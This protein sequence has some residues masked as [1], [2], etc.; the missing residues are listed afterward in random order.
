MASPRLP[1]DLN[2]RGLLDLGE[3]CLDSDLKAAV[4]DCVASLKSEAGQAIADYRA[5]DKA[6][7]HVSPES[8]AALLAEDT[9]V[10]GL[11][12]DRSLSNTICFTAPHIEGA[13][14]TPTVAKQR[15]VVDRLMGRFVQDLFTTWKDLAVTPSGLLWYPPGCAM[16][17]H[18]NSNSAGWR[19][20]MN[21][22]EEE[23]KSFFR[24]R[25]P[26]NGEIVTLEDRQWNFRIFR[27]TREDPLWHC[28]Y[29]DT[30]RFSI[31][32]KILEPSFKGA[33][34]NKLKAGIGLRR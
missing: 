10:H 26:D 18:T 27:V 6:L 29:S 33:V 3:A 17:W 32:Y 14:N 4:L 15:R 2:S 13:V 25:D 1:I 5:D 11:A 23:G 31:G 8:L 22:C 12:T 19:V 9:N 21:Y 34:F 24:Y 28:I 16:G 30:N 7:S 20:Y